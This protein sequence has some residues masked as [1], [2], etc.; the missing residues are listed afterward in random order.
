MGTNYSVINLEGKLL[1]FGFLYDINNKLNLQ[2][3]IGIYIINLEKGEY[4]YSEKL[5]FT[6]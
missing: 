6:Q 5:L 2:L 3:D 4:R 1:Y